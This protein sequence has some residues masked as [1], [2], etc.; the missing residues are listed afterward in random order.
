MK[1]NMR[2]KAA[3]GFGGLFAAVLCVNFALALASVQLDGPDLLVAQQ[4]KDIEKKLKSRTLHWSPPLIEA[5]VRSRISSPPCVL[6]NVLEKAG[7]RANALADNLQNFAAEE[8]ISYEV[9]DH[10]GDTTGRGTGT[11]DY[12]VD[13]QQTLAG[14]VVQESRN[15]R[16]GTRLSPATTQDVGLAEMALIFLPA[17]QDDYE[18]NCEA[19]T[20]WE[21]QSVWLVRFRQRRDKQGHTL[22]FRGGSAVYPARLKGRAWI[23]TNSGEVVHMETGLMEEIPAANVRHWYLSVGYAPVQFRTRNVSIW[24]PQTVDAYG[25][26]DDYRTIVYHTFTNFILSS[27][28][29]DQTIEKPR[30]P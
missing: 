10:L 6:V 8:D 25:E 21:R 20:E 13:F 30:E 19:T 27:V 4:L 2:L 24:L 5:S 18:M 9:F 7:A 15:P 1:D 22:S 3:R 28:Q 12:V 16:H 26:F 11:F 14:L 23:T 29:I 17:M